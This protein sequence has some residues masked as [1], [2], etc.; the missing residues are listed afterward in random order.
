MRPWEE[1]MPAAERQ[2]YQNAGYT[3]QALPAGRRP[4]FLIV[5]VTQG[6]T[7]GP[8]PQ[9]AEEYATAC[10]GAWEAVAVI[11]R[12]LRAVRAKAWPVVYTTGDGPME[13]FYGGATKRPRSGGDERPG[14]DEIPEALA[15][16]AADL[17]IKKNK[18]S[19]FFATPLADYLRRLGT[20]A[21]LI[22][23]ASTSGCVRATVVDA[24]SHNFYPVVVEEATFDRSPTL[25]RA[26]LFDMNAKYAAVVT[27]EQAMRWI[28]AVQEGGANS[29]V[30]TGVGAKSK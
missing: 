14:R 6:F 17:V 24:F 29:E 22:A 1:F 26:N 4:A 8:F 20:D 18:A 30:K 12:L 9:Q 23:G 19:A 16:T 27:V 2:V 13:K 25:H 7:G 3:G 28:D 10:Q 21:L 5:D 15:P 11:A